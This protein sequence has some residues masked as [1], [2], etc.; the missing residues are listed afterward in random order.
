MLINV[1]AS[2]IS[3]ALISPAPGL[4]VPLDQLANLLALTLVFTIL[5]LL[6]FALAF[7]IMGKVT[8]FSIRKEIEDD[9]NT[10]LAIVMGS[11]VL[12]IAIIV[13]SA[14]HG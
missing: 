5:G 1:A 10:A 9:Q 2:S 6:L 3:S 4:I 13:A 8:P 14:V 11:V 12:G 7:W